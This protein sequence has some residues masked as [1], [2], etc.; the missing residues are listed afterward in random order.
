MSENVVKKVRKHREGSKIIVAMKIVKDNFGNR[1]NK[2]IVAML[3][4]QLGVDQNTA[5]VYSHLSRVELGLPTR[6]RK[7]KA[8]VQEMVVST[9][10][11][12]D[13][14]GRFVKKSC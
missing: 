14:K 9:G 10:P 7:S 13:N 12:R 6:P 8:R 4:E 5:Y 1:S 2:E 3:S 11:L